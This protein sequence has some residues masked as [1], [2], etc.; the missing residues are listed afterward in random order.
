MTETKE[1]K[2]VREREWWGWLKV[3]PEQLELDNVMQ[4]RSRRERM[5]EWNGG[6]EKGAICKTNQGI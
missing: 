2:R 6:R 1:R 5:R 3:L 4:E